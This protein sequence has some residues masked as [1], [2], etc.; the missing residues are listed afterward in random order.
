MVCPCW[1]G[2]LDGFLYGTKGAGIADR[3]GDRAAVQTA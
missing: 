2:A 3:M 1:E